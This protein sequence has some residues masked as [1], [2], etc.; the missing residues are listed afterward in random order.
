[1]DKKKPLQV[2]L[3][4]D[5]KDLLKKSADIN[6]RSLTTEIEYILESVLTK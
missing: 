3:S 1:M 5:L 6:K 4:D 2:Y